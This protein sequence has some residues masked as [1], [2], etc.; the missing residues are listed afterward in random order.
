MN[1]NAEA[2][3]KGG[4]A[5]EAGGSGQGFQQQIIGN[6]PDAPAPIGFT[7]ALPKKVKLKTAAVK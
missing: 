6:K 1:E 2:V 5:V 4:A 7:F 3:D